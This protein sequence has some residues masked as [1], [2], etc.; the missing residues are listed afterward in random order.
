MASAVLYTPEVLALATSLADHGWDKAL[1]L[2]GS[3]RS[4]SCGSTLELGLSLDGQGRIDRVALTSHAC[5][6]GQA[7]AAIFARGAPGCT[8]SDIR[9]AHRAM[10]DWLSGKANVPNWPGLAAIAPARDY[11]GRHSAILLAWQAAEEALFSND[12]RG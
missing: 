5:A 10:R 3:G 8:A 6:I 1:P 12:P 2:K 11:P 7:A 4:R 9:A